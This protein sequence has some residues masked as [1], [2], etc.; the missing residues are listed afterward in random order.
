MTKRNRELPD[1][2]RKRRVEK[3]PLDLLTADGI[4][5]VA[6]DDVDAVAGGRAHAVRGR[7]DKRVYAGADV[8][9]IDDENV[10]IPQHLG[11]RLAGFAVEGE[12][13]HAATRI[14]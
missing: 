9:Q 7:V 12:N 4:R 14:P 8:L 6:D 11:G 5:P 3:I 13:R 1:E 2:G 10:D